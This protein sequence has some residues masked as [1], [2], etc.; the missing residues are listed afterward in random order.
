MD[1]TFMSFNLRYN[2]IQDGENAWPYRV[3]KVAEVIRSH[4]PLIIGTQEGLHPMLLDME[5]S[6]PQYG[7]LGEGRY[8][9][10]QDE[11]N[12]IWYDKEQL[13]VLEHGQFWLSE[14]PA[15]PG[16]IS[17]SSSLPRICTWARFQLA[18]DSASEFIVFN[19]H[20]DH[21]SEEAQVNGIRLVR[22]HME[23][24][25]RKRALPMI[26]MGDFNSAP[27]SPVLNVLR[28]NPDGSVLSLTDAYSAAAGK[29]GAT[30]HDFQGGEDGE[31]IDYI[32]VSSDIRV[33]ATKVIRD[34]VNGGYPSDH[35][36]V[37]ARVSMS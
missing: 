19:T 20:L 14:Q 32:F 8:G 4:E 30:F 36:P 11:H 28:S 7:F 26:L 24:Q 6:L 13:T 2:E 1:A 21:E 33:I 12:A 17:W 23:E 35:Y 9:G 10:H 34:R 15:H 37:A 22:Q 18:K 27:D 25:F 5:Q 31:A 3:D 29:V 16:S